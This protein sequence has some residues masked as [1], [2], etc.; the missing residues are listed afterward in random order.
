[1]RI[2][3]TSP[4]ILVVDDDDTFRERLARALESRGYEVRTAPSGE[5]ALALA[6]VESP[7]MAVID[8]KMPGMTGLEL[9]RQLRALDPSTRIVMLTGFGSVAT[10]VEAMRDGAISYLAKPAD[11]DQIVAALT[12]TPAPAEI[13]VPT[14]A[15]AEWEHIH[16]VLADCGGSISEAA[17][18]LGTHRRSL[19]RKLQKQPPRE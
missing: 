12:G 4:S 11:A 1:M 10:A 17:R 14:L 2:E 9:L 3:D 6:R 16:R 15:R 8:L 19:Q 18:R 13:Q 5:V 7:E